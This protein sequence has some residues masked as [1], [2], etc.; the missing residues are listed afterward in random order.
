MANNIENKEELEEFD[1]YPV[2]TLTDEDTGE[3]RDFL[4]LASEKVD[5]QLYYALQAADDESNE[6]VIL[7]VFE[8]GEDI[9]FET[10]EDDEEFEKME[11]VFNDMLFNADVDYDA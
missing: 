10:I 7:K 11:D 6:Y 1:E 9:V 8:D 2:L 4:L 5:G 3:E